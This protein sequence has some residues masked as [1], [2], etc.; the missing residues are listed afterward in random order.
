MRVCSVFSRAEETTHTCVAWKSDYI[1]GSSISLVK[2]PIFVRPHFAWWADTYAWLI[3]NERDSFVLS[4]LPQP[5]VECRCCRII[6][7]D[8]NWLNNDRSY[9]CASC[10]SLCNYVL[11]CFN[12]SIF[13]SL[14]FGFVLRVGIFNAWQGCNWPLIGR[15]TSINN[16]LIWAAQSCKTVAMRT[17]T[18]AHDTKWIVVSFV[19]HSIS[20]Q[21]YTECS[22]VCR[23]PVICKVHL[24]GTLWSYWHDNFSE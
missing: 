11:S 3:N 2:V 24:R 9:V 7:K 22:F 1:C 23:C 13:L 18:E 20:K 6:A 19:S 8:C 10:S 21:R 5:F 12:A 4:N 16:L 14:V 15:Y 17:V